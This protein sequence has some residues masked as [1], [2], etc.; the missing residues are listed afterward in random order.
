MF[1]GQYGIFSSQNR[2]RACTQEAKLCPDGS[3]VGRTGPNCEFGECSMSYNISN[4]KLY[5]NSTVGYEFKYPEFWQV[6]EEN[7]YTFFATSLGGDPTLSVRTA[8]ASDSKVLGILGFEKKSD[9]YHGIGR[10]GL[11]GPKALEKDFNGI[12]FVIGEVS[13]GRF[14]KDGGY[15]GLYSEYRAFAAHGKTYIVLQAVDSELLNIILST[16]QFSIGDIIDTS[17]WKTYRNEKYGFEV[18]WPWK[19]SANNS[20]IN[21]LKENDDIFVRVLDSKEPLQTYC[22]RK[23]CKE[24]SIQA[25]SLTIPVK[26][27]EDATSVA[28]ISLPDGYLQ[29]F[30]GRVSPDDSAL[31]NSFL[32]TFKFVGNPGWNLIKTI[33]LDL[34][35]DS[36]LEAVSLYKS[37]EGKGEAGACIG[38]HTPDSISRF[39]V[40]VAYA[41]YE[42]SCDEFGVKLIIMQNGKLLYQYAPEYPKDKGLITDPIFFQNDDL[43]LKDVTNDGRPEL[44]F[45]TGHSFASDWDIFEHIIYYDFDAKSYVDIG[46]RRFDNGWRNTFKWFDINGK[47]YAVTAGN[48]P[49]FVPACHACDYLYQ[50]KVYRWDVSSKKFVLL[51]TLEGKKFGSNVNPLEQDKDFIVQKI[52]RGLGAD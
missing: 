27:L 47:S 12:R 4:G 50:Y 24:K 28:E 52:E 3:A 45:R 6:T 14:H 40:R 46:D 43:I 30:M 34:N 29:F 22:D 20:E 17:S 26:F 16:F 48:T 25:G 1:F 41:Q 18:K 2:I 8:E 10:Q 36:K 15:I 11:L 49:G 7:D 19:I 39:F 51:K 44:I 38:F 9:G 42:K 5:R 33:R 32:S 37:T 35:H 23:G 21:F 31:F 13:V